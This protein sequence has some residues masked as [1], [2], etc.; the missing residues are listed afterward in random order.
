MVQAL[1]PYRAN[2]PLDI[3]SLP[4]R[5]RCRQNFADAHVAHLVLEVI[6]ENSIAVT[7]Y[8][9]RELLKGK[10]LSQLLSCPL[11]GRMSGDI[12][13]N[14]ATPIIGQY[15]KHVKDLEAESGH[16]EEVDGG[17]LLEVIVQECA[18]GL[19]GRPRGAH[20]VFANAAFTDVQAE[21]EQ[22][23]VDAGFTPTGILLAHLADQISDLAGNERSSTLATSH[24]PGPEQAKACTMPGNYRFGL[25]DGQCRAPVAPEAGEPHP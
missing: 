7:K 15:Q 17:Q 21:S 19:R 24:L 2:H 14:N 5:A 10:G 6:A 23:T 22:L 11:R 9:T 20:H 3:G 8:V 12:A 1:A 13:V 4:R 25:D 18:P 16:G